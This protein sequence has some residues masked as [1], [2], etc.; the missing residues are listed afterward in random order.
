[1]P[2]V[3][4]GGARQDRTSQM[5]MVLS[6]QAAGA[7]ATASEGVAPTDLEGKAVVRTVPRT[8]PLLHAGFGAAQPCR[9][10]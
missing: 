8:L 1:M 9:S 7:D 10:R 2:L 5:A 6:A 4:G 3:V